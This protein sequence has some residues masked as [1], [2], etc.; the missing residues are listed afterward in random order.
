[1]KVSITQLLNAANATWLASFPG[2]GRVYNFKDRIYIKCLKKLK[3]QIVYSL[4]DHLQPNLVFKY[5]MTNTICV[6]NLDILYYWQAES[7][8]TL[9]GLSCLR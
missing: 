5:C 9:F 1:M 3:I 7:S 8:S 4:C 6:T 2:G